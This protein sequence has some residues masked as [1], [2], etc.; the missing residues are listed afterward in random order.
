MADSIFISYSRKDQEYVRKL[1]EDLNQRVGG[2]VWFDQ[3][4]IQAGDKW[5]DRITK[6]VQ[7]AQVVVL[8]LSPDSAASKYVQMEINLALEAGRTIIPILYRPVQLTGELDEFVRETQFIDLQRGSY[9]D[10]FQILVDALIANGIARGERPFLRTSAETDWS[11]VLSKVPGWA[12]AWGIGWAFFWLIVVVFLFTIL[13]VR[14]EMGGDDFLPFFIMILSGGI[15][16][17]LG[18]LLAGLITMLAL[19]PYAPSISWKHMFRS[20]RIWAISGPLG[21]LISGIIT[22]LL[23]AAGALGVES[24]NP[25]CSGISFSEC[26]GQVFGSALGQ[27][28]AIVLL[29]LLVFLLFLLAAWFCTGLFAGW[30]AVKHIRTLEPG[31]TRGQTRWVMFGWGL[32]GLTG[33]ILALLIMGTTSSALGL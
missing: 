20:I 2:G 8:V 4:D 7:D 5:R 16:G 26:A 25:D 22:A 3:S 11:A 27:A 6:G 13:L 33:T 21:M 32:G 23:I 15:G 18:G 29:I 9:T 24:S 10:N 30:L 14:G 31:I 19:R 12:F 1:A 17:F 28:I